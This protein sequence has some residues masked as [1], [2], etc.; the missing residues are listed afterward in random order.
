MIFNEKIIKA[1]DSST[2]L[3]SVPFTIADDMI[4]MLDSTNFFK[5]PD[6]TTTIASEYI[7]SLS[8]KSGSLLFSFYKKFMIALR[9]VFP[10]RDDRDYFIVRN[11][12]FGLCPSARYLSMLRTTFY[13]N[14]KYDLS[15]ELGN[16][17]HYDFKDQIG[18][19]RKEAKELLN[20]MRFDVVCGNPPYN[21]DIYLDFI[22][23][24][25]K[26]AKT[27]DLW[28]TPAKWQAKAGDKNKIIRDLIS[29]KATSIVY[30]S[31]AKDIF[32]ITLG[33]GLTYYLL[34]KSNIDF[35]I[36]INR[37]RL[38]D[39]FNSTETRHLDSNCILNNFL[40]SL[41]SKIGD[42]R[43]KPYSRV[44]DFFGFSSGYQGVDCGQY[45]LLRGNE[46][47][48]Y[49]DANNIHKNV[50]DLNY[51]KVVMHLMNSGMSLD[52]SGTTLGIKPVVILNKD[53]LPIYNYMYLFKSDSLFYCNSFAT[54]MQ[55]KF[56]KFIIWFSLC[57]EGL[58]NDEAWRFVPDPGSFDKVYEDK[59]LEGYTPDENGIYTDNDG[60]VHCSLYVKYK[61]TDE[62]INVIESV[63][64]ERK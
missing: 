36:I 5:E 28:I 58:N 22:E 62:E 57:G 6:L 45:K 26:L 47:V 34:Q 56:V 30:Y 8:C 55:T 14:K 43:F 38:I 53:E 51:Y 21:G 40:N 29:N 46:I 10:D 35:S 41:V 2:S 60:V 23:L 3:H 31:D 37:S 20:K 63:I 42:Y 54:F 7:N 11:L 24:G 12:L 13:S 17:Y 33:G 19:D 4:N 48:G 44:A 18:V 39:S 9:N 61:L 50:E 25:H 59:P 1:L 49:I 16:F 15:N 32:D 64:R 52:K 27:Y